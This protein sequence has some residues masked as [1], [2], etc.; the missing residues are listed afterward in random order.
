MEDPT[1]GNMIFQ[2]SDKE[3]FIL[4]KN[5]S[6]IAKLI[7]GCKTVEQ[8]QSEVGAEL[9]VVQL[10]KELKKRK[11]LNYRSDLDDIWG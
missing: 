7:D 5:D 8:I 1:S 4:G 9:D 11:L 2:I 6:K 3:R 10:L